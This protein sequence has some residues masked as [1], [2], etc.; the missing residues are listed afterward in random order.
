MK[1]YARLQML[2]RLKKLDAALRR[3][4]KHSHDEDAVHDLRVAIRRYVQCLKVFQQFFDQ[5]A[6]RKIRRRL[7]KLMDRCA[8]ARNYH[9][10]IELLRETGIEDESLLERLSARQAEVEKDLSSSLKRWRHR[11][12]RKSWAGKLGIRQSAGLWEKG[13]PPADSAHAVLPRLA[14]RLFTAGNKAASVGAAQESMHQ[15]RILAKRFRYTLE[16]FGSAYG[17]DL[18]DRLEDLKTLQDKLGRLNDFVTTGDLIK[19]HPKAAAVMSARAERCETEF[20]AHW[21]RRFD[22]TARKRWKVWLA[23]ASGAEAVKKTL[24]A[25]LHT[26]ARHSRVA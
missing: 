25:D 6:A 22:S 20:R 23:G 9:V 18:S 14:G 15:F 26:Q 16:L 24:H 5:Q 21:K 10:G 3:A 12:I 4:A 17:E 2:E 8:E 19:D 11:A 7:G 1:K 13:R